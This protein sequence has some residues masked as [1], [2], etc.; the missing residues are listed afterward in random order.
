MQSRSKLLIAVGA[1]VIAAVG[2]ACLWW[3]THAASLSKFWDKN[4]ATVLQYAV[5]PVIALLG[6][7]GQRLISSRSRRSTPE[8]LTQAQQALGRR[9]LEWWR[10]VPE[11]AWPGQVPH[12]GFRPLDVP[13]AQ[14]TNGSTIAD[15]PASTNVA[16]LAK[17]LRDHPTGRLLIRGEAG[18]GKSVFARQLMAEL[19][20]D[21]EQ[22]DQVPVFLPLWSWDPDQH[23]LNDSGKHGLNDWI[24]WRIG[25]AYP[26]LGEVATYGPTAIADLVDQGRVLPVLDG[27]DALPQECRHAVLTNREFMSQARLIVT[28]RTDVFEQVRDFVVIEPGPVDYGK[29]EEFLREVTGGTDVM[30]AIKAQFRDAADR[31][32]KDAMSDPRIIYL[33]SIVYR[34]GVKDDSP[35]QDADTEPALRNRIEQFLIGRLIPALL[36]AEGPWSRRFPWYPSGAEPWLRFLAEQD[37]RD[38]GERG[39]PTGLDDP[40]TSRIAWWNL[41]RAVDFLRDYQALLRGL[42]AGIVVFAVTAAIFQFHSLPHHRHT[43]W[44]YSLLTAGAYGAMILITCAFLGYPNSGDPQIPFQDDPQASHERPSRRATLWWAIRY[45]WAH[46]WRIVVAAFLSFC[47]FGILIGIRV[48]NSNGTH[49]GIRTGFYDGL[50]QGALIVVITYIV[51]GVPAAPRTVRAS[52]H[53][54]AGQSWVRSFATALMIGIPFGV[55]W[56]A[57]AV[58][59]E[60]NGPGLGYGTTILTGLITGV[61]FVLGAWLFRWSREWFTPANAS[62]PRFTARIDLAGA[63]LRPFILAVTFAFSF[64]VS[65]PFNFTGYDVRAWFVVGLVFGTLE[66]EWLLYL[67]AIIWLS[68]LRRKLPLRLMRFLECCRN[69]GILRMIGQE[70]QIHDVGLLKW[71]RPQPPPPEE[72]PPVPAKEAKEFA[73]ADGA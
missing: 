4:G 29:A 30:G 55:L 22:E 27:L 12:A 68:I 49:T 2:I 50:A 59:K 32:F 41:H 63:L 45:F 26:E 31:D 57:G 51:A 71:L 60:Q 10:A 18:T 35:A 7:I 39:R 44:T 5:P 1:F 20:Q 33:A 62:N 48:G 23:G 11:P 28:G 8:Q 52:D 65:A 15:G 70:Y 21:R 42:V 34:P 53:G 19:L 46:W 36:P 58:L 40:G 72:P 61:D 14:V 64:G 67:A 43:S 24:K 9:G 25:Q 73:G 17:W 13:W 3:L 6:W 56:G 37:L 47:C 54:N 38:P 66:S 69:V 16:G